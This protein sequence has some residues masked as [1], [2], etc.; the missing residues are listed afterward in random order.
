MDQGK[1]WLPY[2]W[3]PRVPA[4]GAGHTQQLEAL[5]AKPRRWSRHGWPHYRVN[6]HNRDPPILVI[7]E[8]KMNDMIYNVI[9]NWVQG[10][11]KKG[12]RSNC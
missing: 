12:L 4:S 11:G 1:W 9:L 8:S 2:P 6:V 5:C 7:M 10:I 3:D